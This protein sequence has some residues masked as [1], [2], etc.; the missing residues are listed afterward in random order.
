MADGAAVGLRKRGRGD[1]ATHEPKRTKNG[2]AEE[3]A[4]TPRTD[5]GLRP[6]RACNNKQWV[7]AAAAALA[8]SALYYFGK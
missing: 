6:S 1:V 7:L 8:T 2:G 4:V 5:H 3:L